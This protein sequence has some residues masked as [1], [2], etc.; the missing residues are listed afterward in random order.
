MYKIKYMGQAE[1]NIESI[2]YY[3]DKIDTRLTD[4]TLKAINERIYSLNEMPFRYPRYIDNPK[5]RY[6]T[7]K[8]Y[9]IFYIVDEAKKVIE[10]HRILHGTQNT[11]EHINL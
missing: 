5:Y 4:T 2:E 9:M 7:V 10:I 1:R 8:K 11:K 3:L 6:T